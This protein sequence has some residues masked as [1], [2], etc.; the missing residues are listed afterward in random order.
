[1]LNTGYDYLKAAFAGADLTEEQMD[2]YNPFFMNRLLSFSPEL[3][4][5]SYKVNR[6]YFITN[7]LQHYRMLLGHLKGRGQFIKY[8]KAEKRIEESEAL[9]ILA[10]G[11][12]QLF[13]WSKREFTENLLFMDT[14]SN[15]FRELCSAVGMN[16]K[17]IQT[18]IAEA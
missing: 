17:E 3:R 9:R 7:K 8:D 5:L 1:M 18:V 14:K 2:N 16:E 13:G 12:K 11:C 15:S 6:W 4:E 10:N